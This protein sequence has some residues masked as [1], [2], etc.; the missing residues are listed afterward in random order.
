MLTALLIAGFALATDQA[1][2]RP[3]VKE[4]VA[5][6]EALFEADRFG[7]D[8]SGFDAR[9]AELEA[10]EIATPAEQKDWTQRLAKIAGKERKLEKK[11]GTYHWFEAEKRGLFIVGGETSRPKGLLIAFHGGGAGSG[12]ATTAQSAFSSAASKLDW[13]MICPEVLEKTARGWTDSGTEEFVVQLVEAAMRTW[14]IDFD[15]VYFSGHSMGGYGTWT[16]GAHHADRVAALAPS[17]GAPTPLTGP[18]GIDDIVPGVVPNLRN[19]KIAIYQSD[20]DPRVPPIANR[21]A[22]QKLDEAQKRWGGFEHEYWEV[23]NR[24][25]ELPP[26]GMEALLE[27]I[28]SAK[29]DARPT[30]IVWQPSLAWKRQFYWLWWSK[31]V[32]GT[33]LVADV[34]R[35][36]NVIVITA[37]ADPKGL[38]V[39]L[40]ERLVDMQRE[41]VVKLGQ[42][43]VY[44]GIPRA[45]LGTL[46]KTSL[47]GDPDLTFAVRVKVSP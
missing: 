37:G 24:Q 20:D 13:L 40:D 7:A 35:K 11:R 22:A 30:R 6:L 2:Q 25:H 15:R 3:T 12:D 1:V 39:L 9:L 8:L 16:L 43:E 4:T 29:R 44:R 45:D 32:A 5:T 36:T 42:R 28:K 18:T 38:E 41:V 19:V 27:K 46:A 14:K 23:P 33:T 21:V 47:S 34:D 17:A 26:G 10:V 31:P